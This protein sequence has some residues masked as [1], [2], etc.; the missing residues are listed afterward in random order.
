M[1]SLLFGDEEDLLSKKY[2]LVRNTKLVKYN[3]RPSDE[4]VEDIEDE[5]ER[6]EVKSLVDQY[7][8]L[9]S[10]GQPSSMSFCYLYFNLIVASANQ[11]KPSASSFHDG[12]G[13][14]RGGCP[15]KKSPYTLLSTAA[16]RRVMEL[17]TDPM[18]L[19]SC[20]DAM[21]PAASLA[22]TAVEYYCDNNLL[23]DQTLCKAH[24]LVPG[25]AIDRLA[26][27]CMKEILDGAGSSSYSCAL[28]SLGYGCPLLMA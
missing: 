4:F 3:G 27:T 19:A 7:D 2:R 12:N 17:W 25:L 23:C 6:E 5:T 1:S 14:L 18:V 16:L 26:M 15:K 22:V 13:S 21:A 9:D 11:G 10:W 24:E 8:E 20:G 28:F